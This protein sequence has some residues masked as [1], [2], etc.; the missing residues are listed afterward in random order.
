[1][2]RQTRHIVVRTIYF[3]L[4]F[5]LLMSGYRLDCQLVMIAVSHV[6]L[7]PSFKIHELH[8]LLINLEV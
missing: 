2:G 6:P 7:V 1:M 3:S 5:L 8:C 4:V